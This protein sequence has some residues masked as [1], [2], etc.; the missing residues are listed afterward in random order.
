VTIFDQKFNWTK[1]WQQDRKKWQQDR[2]VFNRLHNKSSGTNDR[3][4]DKRNDQ[5]KKKA[6]RQICDTQQ[7]FY[8]AI[9]YLADENMT[10]N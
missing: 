4:K 2:F 9:K 7:K 8:F 1:K 10:R 5:K 3:V 6:I